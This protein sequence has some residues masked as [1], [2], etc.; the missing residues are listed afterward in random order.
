MRNIV[1][2]LLAALVGTG[3][4]AARAGARAQPEP[5]AKHVVIIGVDGLSPVGIEHADTP[6]LD[7]LIARGSYTMRARGVFP[8][9]SAP[10]WAS[11]LMGA[12]PEQ[13]GVTSND[14]RR[15]RRLIEPGDTGLDHEL[16]PTIFGVTRQQRPD[17]Y[18]ASIYDWSGIGVLF[19]K[20]AVDLDADTLGPERTVAKAV[21]AFK[22]QKPTLTF[23]HLDH[24]DHAGHGKGWHTPEY[25]QAVAHA[26]EL[27]GLLI[28]GLADAGM[29]RDTAII[30]TSDH[31]G[32]GQSHGGESME[33]LLIPWIITGSG[34][35]PGR[36]IWVPVN[37]T[38]TAATAALLLGLD[39]PRSWTGQA[40]REALS[41]VSPPP[42]VGTSG[43]FL[44]RPLIKPEGGLYLDDGP[45]VTI[46]STHPAAEIRYTLDGSEPTEQSPIYAGPIEVDA[47]T[48]V[49]SAS[50][51]GGRRSE[52]WRETYRIAKRES[53]RGVRFEYYEGEWMR[54]PAF[55]SLTPVSTG[56]APEFTLRGLPHRDDHFAVRFSARLEVRT[57]G[58]HDFALISDDGSRL[59]VNG[60][61]VVDNDGDHGA[62]RRSGS[63]DLEPGMHDVVVEYFELRGGQSLRVLFTEPGQTEQV[64][65]MEQ[66]SPAR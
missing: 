17:A 56:W 59:L 35:A 21:E 6:V 9:S 14:W 1:T 28:E 16:F 29:L 20:S 34:I 2:W 5:I 31:G 64:I 18:I 60:H 61:P 12:G 24:V 58:R 25:Y 22:A 23:V 42:E 30:I 4:C 52:V 8:T 49:A 66:L 54:L 11:M 7:E 53:G 57:Q 50:F 43:L 47:T 40:V 15:N 65:P 44:P 19:E 36:E 62:V 13:H 33:E 55:D 26:D 32:V 63:I 46:T 48:T 37:T 38:D 45:T 51:L 27:I 10:N 41:S 3:A 39:A